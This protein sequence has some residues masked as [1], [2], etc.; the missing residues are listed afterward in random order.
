MCC[1]HPK[2]AQCEQAKKIAADAIRAQT[3]A[4]E[5]I[6]GQSLRDYKCEQAQEIERKRQAYVARHQKGGA[7]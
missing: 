1:P 7:L 4:F 3:E 2:C 5:Q 6:F